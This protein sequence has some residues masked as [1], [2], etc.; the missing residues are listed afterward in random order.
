MAQHLQEKAAHKKQPTIRPTE[1][2]CYIKE[3]THYATAGAVTA[4]WIIP[5]S[6]GQLPVPEALNAPS[7]TL[8]ILY[9]TRLRAGCKAPFSNIGKQIPQESPGLRLAKP[10]ANIPS[11]FMPPGTAKSPPEK[12][13]Y[14]HTFTR[15]NGCAAARESDPG[16]ANPIIHRKKKSNH[17][18]FPR[19]AFPWEVRKKPFLHQGLLQ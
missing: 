18:P 15:G 16:H 10:R 9:D 5:S 4:S 1:Y 8:F 12:S 14:S 11:V 6:S 19:N 7:P 13:T 2:R 3:V 17:K